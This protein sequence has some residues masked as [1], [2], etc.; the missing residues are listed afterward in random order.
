MLSLEVPLFLAFLLRFDLKNIY[1]HIYYNTISPFWFVWMVGRAVKAAIRRVPLEVFV[2]FC[3]V[4]STLRFR[5]HND[6]F[7]CRVCSIDI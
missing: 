3:S 6:H 4:L 5:I 1:F 2:S 7:P